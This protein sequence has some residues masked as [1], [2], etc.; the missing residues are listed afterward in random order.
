MS[1]QAAVPLSAQSTPQGN[2]GQFRAL[3]RG[4]VVQAPPPRVPAAYRKKAPVGDPTPLVCTVARAATLVVLGAPDLDQLNRWVST[5]VRSSLAQQHSLARR[6]G[7]TLKGQVGIARVRVCRVSPT[8]VEA[9]VVATEGET[10]R[11]IAMRLEIVAGR[12]LVTAL[13]IG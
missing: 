13:T 5:E 10:A 11:A 12:W 1:A 2:P 4:R 3:P 6:A 7:Y 9:A 8:A